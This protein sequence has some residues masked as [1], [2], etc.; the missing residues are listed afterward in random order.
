MDRI[1][2]MVINQIIRRVINTGINAGLKGA[3]QVA[4]NRRRNRPAPDA[5]DPAPQDETRNS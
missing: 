2:Q 5:H 4:S 3:G 1:I